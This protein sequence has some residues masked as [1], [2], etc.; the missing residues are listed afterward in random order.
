MRTWFLTTGSLYNLGNSSYGLPIT[1]S[2][3]W[4]Y[5][6][7]I[8]KDIA[9]FPLKIAIFNVFSFSFTSEKYSL[10]LDYQ[11]HLYTVPYHARS[12]LVF[13]SKRLDCL[14][15]LSPKYPNLLKPYD[16]RHISLPS[17]NQSFS[18]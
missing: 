1:K 18:H 5:F 13:G 11:L 3:L 10:T 9:I 16:I 7:S 17:P 15:L 6:V 12:Q 2:I 14:L 8:L 4:I